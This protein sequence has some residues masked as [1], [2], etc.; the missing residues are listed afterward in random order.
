MRQIPVPFFSPLGSLR[1]GANAACSCQMASMKSPTTTTRRW[2]EEIQDRLLNRDTIKIILLNIYIYYIYRKHICQNCQTDFTKYLRI[3]NSLMFLQHLLPLWNQKL[4]SETKKHTAP[5]HVCYVNPCDKTW[6]KQQIYQNMRKPNVEC[7]LRVVLR[8]TTERLHIVGHCWMRSVQ[9][10][11]F[12]QG[13]WGLLRSLS[14]CSRWE[15]PCAGGN[16]PPPAYG[17]IWFH[18][19]FISL[20]SMRSI[21][22]ILLSE[23]LS[24]PVIFG[25]WC[26]QSF[27]CQLYPLPWHWPAQMHRSLPC[28]SKWRDFLVQL[29]SLEK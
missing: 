27:F 18:N 7:A 3:R 28:C 2:D 15:C 23:T 25:S 22:S 29:A 6:K 14:G 20:E 8:S 9:S 21:I 19:G 13:L 5:K 26:V 24:D 16:V 11:G 17:F 12:P 4:N 10:Q 1:P